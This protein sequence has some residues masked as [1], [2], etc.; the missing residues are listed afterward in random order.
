MDGIDSSK[1]CEARDDLSL[2]LLFNNDVGF[3]EPFLS[4]ITDILCGG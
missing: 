2:L 3:V 4:Y 1:V